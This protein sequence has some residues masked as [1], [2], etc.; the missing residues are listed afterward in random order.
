[1]AGDRLHD[2]AAGERRPLE[3]QLTHDVADH[4]CG[5][6]GCTKALVSDGRLDNCA[7][8]PAGVA[9]F[10]RPPLVQT[11]LSDVV[12]R[13]GATRGEHRQAIDPPP[14]IGVQRPA[15]RPFELGDLRLGRGFDLDGA[16]AEACQQLMR[17]AGQ[18]G[19]AMLTH[20][21]PDHPEPARQ[22][23]SQRGLVEHAG[24]LG[25]L[26]QRPPVQRPPGAILGVAN[27][28]E[29]ETVRVQLRVQGAAGA[30]LEPGDY[31]PL[32][33]ADHHAVATTTRER[34]VVLEIR[35]PCVLDR[36]HMRRP[37]QG[38]QLSIAESEQQR[39]RL[40]GRERRV[41]ADHPVGTPRT[42]ELL[43]GP[44]M[45]RF[46]ERENQRLGRDRAGDTGRGRAGT[47]PHPRRFPRARVVVLQAI[48]DLAG[49]VLP[50]CRL[51][52]ADAQHRRS[53]PARLWR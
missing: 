22:L 4:V 10:A 24:R 13:F 46:T 9:G 32:G 36:R 14:F 17:D 49:V 20:R 37:H 51:H 45:A 27:L 16:G 7:R 52:H 26:E 6:E 29:D 31:Q 15:E 23:G 34:G 48:G 53:L 28:V 41:E 43:A 39:H 18:F 1:M 21:T 47:G 44:G 50:P 12:V 42:T 33:V 2:V 3:A 38:A 30:M 35:Q 40:R 11:D 5:C 8:F 25:L 19:L